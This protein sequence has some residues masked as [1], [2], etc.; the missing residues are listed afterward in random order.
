M[1]GKCR[2]DVTLCA[3]WEPAATASLLAIAAA[4]RGPFAPSPARM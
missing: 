2:Q 3:G 4:K 1:S